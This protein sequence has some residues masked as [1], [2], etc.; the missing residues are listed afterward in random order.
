M[1]EIV[2]LKVMST[3][4]FIASTSIL[5]NPSMFGAAPSP[6]TFYI[7]KPA[8]W[9]V[10]GSQSLVDVYSMYYTDLFQLHHVQN[11]QPNKNRGH[12]DISKT[13]QS[14]RTML[15]ISM[16]EL[17]SILGVS[18]K[19]V[20]NYKDCTGQSIAGRPQ[21]RITL[22]SQAIGH[23]E[24]EAGAEFRAPPR[25]LKL[26]KS[27]GDKSVFDLLVSAESQDEFLSAINNLMQTIN[28]LG[29]P[30]PSSKTPRANKLL[31][32]KGTFSGVD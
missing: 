22:L 19:T 14:A 29:P 5:D 24:L 28:A 16:S 23:L 8:E 2:T 21:E 13:I 7:E 10:Y 1:K 25:A 6:K 11:K 26:K 9:G 20:Y 4:N 12:I 31:M 17:A 15:G 27:S 18:R 3:E 30:R 32:T